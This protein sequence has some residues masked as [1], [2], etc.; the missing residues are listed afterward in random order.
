[1]HNDIL[2]LFFIQDIFKLFHSK[3][4]KLPLTYLWVPNN[5]N[6]FQA[7]GVNGRHLDKIT[8][9]VELNYVIT[10]RHQAPLL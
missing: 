10:I 6:F 2:N 8:H 7:N 1:M 5:R 9:L 4:C 3:V